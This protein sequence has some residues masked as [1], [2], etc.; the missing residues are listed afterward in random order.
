[1]IMKKEATLC[2]PKCGN[3]HLQMRAWVDANTFAFI[4][5]CEDYESSCDDDYE[6]GMMSSQTKKHSGH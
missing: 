5:D 2:C 6:E 4:G 1:M 3:V